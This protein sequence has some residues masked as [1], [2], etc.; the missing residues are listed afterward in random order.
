VA[1]ET[2]ERFLAERARTA[3]ERAYGAHMDLVSRRVQV[4]G[5]PGFERLGYD[6]WARQC[7]H[8]FREGILK[9]VSYQGLKVLVDTPTRLMFKTLET[10][11]A[12][13]G[14]VDSRGIEVVI[15]LE[16]DGQWRVTQERVL[17]DEESLH[18][19]L[20]PARA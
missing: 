15:E 20:K 4:F 5:V 6:D 2:A 14:A 1:K 18:D 17:P 19:G 11:E 9:S 8:E 10:V 3:R 12:S 7:E 13:D 16:S